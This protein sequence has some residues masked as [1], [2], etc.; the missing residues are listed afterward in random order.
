MQNITIA[1]V[2]LNCK[3]DQKEHNLEKIHEWTQKACE[4]GAELILF[5]ELSICGWPKSS[6]STIAEAVPGISTDQLSYIAQQQKCYI[7]A[8]LAERDGQSFYSTQVIVGPDGYIGKARKINP[9]PGEDEFSKGDELPVFDIG[10]CKIGFCLCYDIGFPEICLIL[11]LKGA[12]LIFVPRAGGPLQKPPKSANASMKTG[13]PRSILHIA[14]AYENKVYL[15]MTN[16][17]GIAEEDD[18]GKIYYPGMA[19]IISPVGQVLCEF[20]K[21]STKTR[22]L[23]YTMETQLLEE[24]RRYFPKS[25]N[26]FKDR[27]NW[28]NQHLM[29]LLN[30]NQLA[31]G[32]EI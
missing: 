8:G 2:S 30:R 12:E 23:I 4:K 28:I 19:S 20:E 10:K 3:Q 7:S 6:I 15:A 27:I 13:G 26:I 32:T 31:V 11:T 25:D 24:A 14:R 1:V 5:P 9:V 18:Y 17:S 21:Q 22:M 29:K 16:Q